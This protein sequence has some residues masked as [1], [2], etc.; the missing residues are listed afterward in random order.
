LH[1]ADDLVRCQRYYEVVGVPGG[2]EFWMRVWATAAG[3][4]HDVSYGFKATKA[5]SPTLT[6]V[7]TWNVANTPQP[8]AAAATLWGIRVEISSNAAGDMYTYNG[9]AGNCITAEANP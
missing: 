8:N 2:G 7:G 6:K 9:T 3:Q 5:V 1:P 4:Y